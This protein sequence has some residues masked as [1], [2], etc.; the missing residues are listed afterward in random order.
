MLQGLAV[1]TK[2]QVEFVACVVEAAVVSA[3]K[4]SRRR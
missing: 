1:G 3:E 2:V 4:G